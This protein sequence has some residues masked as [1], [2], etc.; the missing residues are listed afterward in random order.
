V[1]LDGAKEVCGSICCGG[2]GKKITRW[3]NEDLRLEIRNTKEKWRKYL[4]TNRAEDYSEYKKQRN[5][6]KELVTEAKKK[7]WEE[8]GKFLEGNAKE[9]QK[10][11]YKVVKKYEK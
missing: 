9:N 6:I 4:R 2:R 1:T 11:F 7:A 3:W 8:S 10:L 5:R